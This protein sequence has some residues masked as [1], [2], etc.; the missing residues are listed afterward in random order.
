[1]SGIEFATK[2]DQPGLSG[3]IRLEVIK[4]KIKIHICSFLISYRTGIK[5][6]VCMHIASKQIELESPGWSGLVEN[7]KPDQT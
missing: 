6:C 4:D 5:S 1:M 2:P 3:L 7:S